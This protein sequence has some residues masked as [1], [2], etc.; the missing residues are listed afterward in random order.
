VTPG[1][2]GGPSVV[3]RVDDVAFFDGEAIARPTTA[4]LGATTALMRRLEVAGGEA[5]RKQLRVNEPLPLGSAVV[6]GAGELGVDLLINAVVMSETEPVSLDVVRRATLSAL[7]RAADWQ[8]ERVAF[9]PFGLGAGNL[10]VEDSAEVMVDSIRRHF[11]HARYPVQ[12]VIVVENDW[13]A[14]VFEARLARAGV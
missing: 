3:V 13:E 9:P 8:L 6:T 5:L 10:D 4:A 7:Q 2:N 1:Q 14:Q 11:G 12:V